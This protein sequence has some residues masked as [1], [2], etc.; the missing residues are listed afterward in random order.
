M[1]HLTRLLV[2]MILGALVGL[3]CL[4]V[5]DNLSL[6]RSGYF[7][8]Q[9]EARFGSPRA[10]ASVAVARRTTP[11]PLGILYGP[12]WLGLPYGAYGYRNGCI[13]SLRWQNTFC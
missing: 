7:L 13:G 6:I 4:V 12:P 9:A 3:G 1:F 2:N 8:A 5:N 11:I 10:P